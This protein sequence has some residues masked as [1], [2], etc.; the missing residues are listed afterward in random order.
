[1]HTAT[2]NPT[3]KHLAA[4]LSAALGLLGLQAHAM[5]G[6]LPVTSCA[7]DNGSG[8]LR[9]VAASAVHGDV[10]DLSGLSC[11]ESTVTLTQG[12]IV[13][14]VNVTLNGPADRTLTLTA[15]NNSRILKSISADTPSYLS[16]AN[17]TLRGGRVYSNGDY[18]DGGCV[19][20]TGTVNLTHSTVTD[21]AVQASNAMAR[22][23][24][25][26][27]ASVQ[28][29]SSRVTGSS[30]RATGSYQLASGGGVYA[31]G[32]TCTDS[33]LSGNVAAADA[34]TMFGE[35][36]GAMVL[37]GDLRLSRCT[38]DTN[39]A[40]SGGGILQFATAD[41]ST[42]IENSTISG[43]TA[44]S[45]YSAGGLH[46][47]CTDCV[48]SVTL[49]NST[50]AFNSAPTQYGAGLFVR[51]SVS[52]QSTII[53][54]NIGTDGGAM[55]LYAYT[56]SGADNLIQSTNLTPDAGVITVTAD[57]Q[58]LPLEDN[59]GA[60]FT[61]ALAQGSPALQTGNNVAQL[62]TDQ[63]GAGFS[64]AANGLVDIGAWQTQ[65]AG[66]P[67]TQQDAI[68]GGKFD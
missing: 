28:L 48:A 63:R 64:R 46:V 12:E 44:R 8:T 68:F 54:S 10:I 33:T 5:A 53:A 6:V 56:L 36:G 13:L 35:G 62:S 30:A 42:L 60:T 39:S 9:Q 7:D 14:P 19:F 23:G 20:A 47:F 45:A 17:L 26:Y 15:Q 66:T 49:S 22:G 38:V 37:N 11:A 67:K 59:G 21:C 40:D 52:A 3:S 50:I 25:I 65:D 18:A 51:G 2:R 1:M 55:D 61:H 24:A 27:A 41:T 34:E 16:V 29:V 31:N 58:L 57:P 4:A 32:L 43:N